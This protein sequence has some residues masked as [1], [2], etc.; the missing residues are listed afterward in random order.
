V[1]LHIGPSSPEGVAVSIGLIFFLIFAMS[2]AFGS[3]PE[4]SRRFSREWTRGWLRASLP[5]MVVAGVFAG[6][7]L[8]GALLYG[9]NSGTQASLNCDRPV[10]PIT[11][12]PVTDDR[13]LVAIDGLQ[14]MVDS[15]NRGDVTE[16]QSIWLT[17]D[18]H[19]LTHDIDRPLRNVAPDLAKSLCEKVLALENVMVG[20]IVAERVA[21]DAASIGEILQQ[22]RALLSN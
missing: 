17:A 3:I 7:V 5:R 20:E 19:N 1:L 12:N 10:P 6:A 8:G 11:G 21:A 15:A 18:V 4:G 22:A 9:G 14:Q 13:V 2:F 16:V